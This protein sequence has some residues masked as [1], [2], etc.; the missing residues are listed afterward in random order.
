MFRLG[1]ALIALIVL[2]HLAAVFGDLGRPLHN[3]ETE[4]LHTTWLMDQGRTIYRDFMQDHPP[5]L[6]QFMS[7][8]NPGQPG[9]IYPL[10]DI[11]AWTNRG[12]ILAGLFGACAL[13]A[14]AVLAYRAARSTLAALVA[15]AYI[16]Q[17]PVIWQRGLTDLRLDPFALAMLWGGACLVVLSLR[18]EP[19]TRD[20][21]VAGIGI[22]LVAA[23]ALLNPKWPLESIVIG[24]VYLVI[25]WRVRLLGFS[26]VALSLLPTVLVL[27]IG[28]WM[29]LSVTT[30]S[31]YVYFTFQLKRGIQQNVLRSGVYGFREGGGWWRVL[32]ASDWIIVLLAAALLVASRRFQ[33]IREEID[34]PR[35]AILFALC[36]AAMAE[37]PFYQPYTVMWPQYRV[38]YVV[39]A[40]LLYGVVTAVLYRILAIVIARPREKQPIVLIV[41]TVAVA[42]LM[43]WTLVMRLLQYERGSLARWLIL[44]C[45]IGVWIPAVA[46]FVHARGIRT[47]PDASTMLP[48]AAVAA[49]AASFA[50][51]VL[52]PAIT[53]RDADPDKWI[54]RAVLQ[55]KLRDGEPVWISSR[56]HPVA[57]FDS[58]YFYYGFG[59][60]TAGALL[61]AEAGHRFL[62]RMSE[63]DLPPC[64]IAAGVDQKTHFIEIGPWLMWYPETARC[65]VSLLERNA[66]APTPHRFVFEVR[67]P[68]DGL[69]YQPIKRERVVLGQL[70]LYARQSVSADQGMAER[71][72]AARP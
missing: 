70:E 61:H 53:G 5:F 7:L 44:A 39:A 52:V 10:L 11:Q 9:G 69:R 2:A 49:A 16:V 14:A 34:V 56:T 58:S 68:N 35:T 26:R 23:A 46:S 71:L 40:G 55:S 50:I 37:L 20:A 6:F 1:A 54:E 18:R 3:D 45:A 31:E 57:A 4:Y 25:L 21:L 15:L 22:A 32:G 48:F 51:I 60:V 12:R 64:R 42:L 59:D 67:R 33:R 41:V 8:F 13:A 29:L 30:F 62:P 28:A 47:I 36:I 43:Q 63:K 66:L 27:A 72:R 38:S 17:E 24:V 65:V 19:R